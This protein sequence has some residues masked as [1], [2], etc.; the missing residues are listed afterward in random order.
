MQ[1]PHSLEA[2]VRLQ[3][4]KFLARS[5][6]NIPS[7]F[8]FVSSSC[9]AAP[10]LKF[11]V[12]NSSAIMEALG[13][14][15]SIIAV[16]DLS[17]KILSLCSQYFKEV[18]NARNSIE[19]LQKAVTNIQTQH[20]KTRAL[21][22]GRMGFLLETSQELIKGHHG[23]KR[24]LEDLKLTLEQNFN[25]KNGS[26]KIMR[27]FGQRA[28]KWPFEASTVHATARKL[29]GFQEDMT[30][31]LIIDQTVVELSDVEHS[32]L[33]SISSIPYEKHHNSNSE[34][35][36]SDTCGWLLLHETFKEW[37]N[38]D[39]QVILWLQG[40][41]GVGKT[42]LVSKAVDHIR[43]IVKASPD[44]G[45]AFFYC[46]HQEDLRRTPVSIFQSLLRQLLL[47]SEGHHEVRKEIYDRWQ[48][49]KSQEIGI[50]LEECQEYLFR[51]IDKSAKTTIVLDGMDECEP[52]SRRIIIEGFKSLTKKCHKPLRILVASR[53]ERDIRDKLAPDSN[54][55]VRE[56]YNEADIKV[57]VTE[58]IV[59]HD[60]WN[61]MPSDIQLKIEE[62]IVDQS[63]GMFQWAALQVQQLLEQESISNIKQ[64][65][66]RLP[67]NL[68][69]TYDELF[70]AIRMRKGTD[71]LLAE[72]ALKWVMCTVRPLGKEELLSATRLKIESDEFVLLEKINEV[73][74]LKLCNHLLVFDTERDVWKFAHFSVAEYLE[75][76]GLGIHKSHSDVAKACLK[77]L[78]QTVVDFDQDEITR[79]LASDV[80]ATDDIFRKEHPVQ[81]YSRHHWIVHAQ[82]QESTRDKEQDEEGKKQPL[83][84]SLARKLKKFMGSFNESS[85]QYRRWLRNID[86]DGLPPRTS[87][88]G[89]LYEKRFNKWSRTNLLALAAAGGSISV[90]EEL[91]RRGIN[92]EEQRAKCADALVEAM[93]HGH[94]DVVNLL[95][96]KGN[97][98]P[99]ASIRSNGNILVRAVLRGSLEEVR[100]IVLEGQTRVNV[101]LEDNYYGRYKED[102]VE[103]VVWRFRKRSRW[104]PVTQEDIDWALVYHRPGSP[105]AAAAAVAPNGNL[106]IVRFLVQEGQADVDMPLRCGRYGTALATAAG[107]GRLN[108]VKFLVQNG[109]AEVNKDLQFGEY[110]SALA[111]AA[112]AGHL[113]VVRFLVQDGQA[114]VNRALQ[115][116]KYRSALEAATEAKLLEVAK[117]LVQEGHA[118]VNMPL[119]RGK[120]GTVL[121]TA[122]VMGNLKVV[123]FLIEECGANINLPEGIRLEYG[124]QCDAIEAARS[125]SYWHGASECLK[126]LEAWKSRHAG[127]H[128]SEV[129]T[130]DQT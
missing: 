8:L 58:E 42:C 109:L 96:K 14:V 5:R 78:N 122:A 44:E 74:L 33:K 107:E 119:Q 40:Q 106:D 37:Q 46:D 75:E 100:T 97:I 124:L 77:L 17:A 86:S 39:S 126:F 6:S 87:A 50:N 82:T 30:N 53:P 92:V 20:E 68:K 105:L 81:V 43:E 128:A 66:G 2:E 1:A 35:R 90:C 103:S 94:V 47:S 38:S 89:P 72:N 65:L 25:T 13:G 59:N 99:N 116:G 101:V 76:I 129:A 117:F 63:H 71:R 62:K 130:N 18:K 21:L 73:Q 88:L 36:T 123:K 127:N 10:F 29:R 84:D 24:E 67:D 121:A 22:E 32:F 57:F 102:A 19:D 31:G 112:E 34:K 27:K 69:G 70:D 113:E 16:V 54:I 80:T 98:D 91:L 41:V 11:G 125:R 56:E 60:N 79:E 26:S 120:Y 110:G 48:S 28:L 52:K 93:D 51:L 7:S 64:R 4:S 45:L 49:Q 23:C 85:P 111:A 61:N 55:E 115:F 83:D 104:I 12:F 9:T 95:I 3:K 15:G 114:E 108:V 118:D